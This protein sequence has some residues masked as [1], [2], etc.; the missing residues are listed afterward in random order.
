MKIQKKC[1][2]CGGEVSRRHIKRCQFCR[3]KWA[4]GENAGNWRG[5]HYCLDCKI[6][7]S[8]GAE[9]CAPCSNKRLM[10]IENNSRALGKRWKLKTLRKKWTKEACERK[11]EYMK[12]FWANTDKKV[13]ISRKISI[14]LTGKKLSKEHIL[15]IS[16]SNH[17]AW[18]LDREKAKYDRRNDPEYLQWRK[19]IHERD[20][21][22]CR[23]NNQNCFGKLEV[24]H[25]LNWTDYPKLHYQIN[26]G[27][28]LCHAHHPRKRAEEKRLIFELQEL[29]SVSNEYL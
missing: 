25:I 1:I 3:G 4:V 24:H 28:T 26:N 7:I 22:K 29:V 15:K 21:Y 18:I 2:D 11:A 6:K 20:Y 16:G 10:G 8:K 5:G 12:K 17:Y 9:R 14:A 27:I 23:I 19:K 13:E